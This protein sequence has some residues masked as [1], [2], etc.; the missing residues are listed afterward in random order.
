[1]QR[2]L[3]DQRLAKFGIV[4]HDQDGASIGHRSKGCLGA[5]VA[6]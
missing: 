1:M 5:I 2:Q 3:F 6:K 4:V